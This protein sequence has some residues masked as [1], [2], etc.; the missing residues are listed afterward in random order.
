M[1]IEFAR[2]DDPFRVQSGAA[3]VSNDLNPAVLFSSNFRGARCEVFSTAVNINA[4]E[5]AGTWVFSQSYSSIP[6]LL[7]A[8]VASDGRIF[9]PEMY[10]YTLRINTDV[11]QSVVDEIKFE[12]GLTNAVWRVLGQNEAKS[13][14]LK[15]WVIG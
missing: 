10:L 7:G 15:A 3:H 2:A 5:Q 1:F 14:T 11:Y 8:F 6:L 4:G 12:V 13:G 9:Y